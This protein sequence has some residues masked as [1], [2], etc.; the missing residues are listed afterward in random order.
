MVVDIEI[1]ALRFRDLKIGLRGRHQITN[2]AVAVLLAQNWIEQH[3]PHLAEQSF[4]E[5]VYTG[6]ARAKN[7]GRFQQIS[8]NPA[9]FI[10]VGHSPAAIDCVVETA[11]SVIRGQPILLVTGVSHNKEVEQIVARLL[12]VA[13]AVI[14]TRAY[15]RGSPV[16]DIVAIV[17][18]YRADLPALAADTIEQAVTLARDIAVERHMTVLI[19]GGLFLAIEAMQSLAG[20]DP[21]A[22]Q[23]F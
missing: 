10:D 7:T 19:A 12:P 8:V 22:L 6:L 1:G 11:R 5:A 9:I 2:A 14:C 18:K 4:V 21:Q 13:S 17:K 23:F 15:H 16:P 20:E 3:Y